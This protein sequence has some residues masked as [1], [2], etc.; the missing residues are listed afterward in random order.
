MTT[1]ELMRYASETLR[2]LRIIERADETMRYGVL[3]RLIGAI[4]ED[5]KW[6]PRH[7]AMLSHILDAT[8]LMAQ[9]NG[10]K[11]ANKHGEPGLAIWRFVNASGGPGVG[12]EREIKVAGVK[13]ARAS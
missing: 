5:G 1:E 9:F 2:I 4:P 13:L 11:I 8:S 10:E 6:E 7:R 3:M 12:V